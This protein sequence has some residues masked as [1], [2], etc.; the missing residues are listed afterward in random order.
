MKQIGIALHTYHDTFGRLPISQGMAQ[1]PAGQ[2]FLQRT[3]ARSILPYVEQAVIYNKWDWTHGHASGTNRQLT[4]TALPFFKCPSSPAPEIITVTGSGADV[5]DPL[6]PTF[7]AGIMEYFGNSVNWD[8]PGRPAGNNDAEVAQIQG[9]I[10]YHTEG[11][12]FAAVTD[13]LTNT[14]MV[15]EC[16][17]GEKRYIG[18]H[19]SPGLQH[20][21][22]GSWATRNRSGIDPYDKSGTV[23][24]GGNCVLNCNNYNGANYYSFHTG[25]VQFILGDGSVRA[26]SENI[27]IDICWR[28]FVRNDGIPI[29]EF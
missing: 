6:G 29:G 12:K 4:A 20:P 19:T 18:N 9:M 22:Q 1:N 7:Q 27:D 2:N 8:F 10:P 15:G 17:G 11:I 5:D 14:V 16:A 24:L 13:G 3:W 28:L 25:I 26:I 23:I 21:T